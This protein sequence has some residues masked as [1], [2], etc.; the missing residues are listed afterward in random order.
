MMPKSSYLFFKVL[1]LGAV[2]SEIFI[3]V[4]RVFRTKMENETQGN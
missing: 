2:V 3:S 4:N 1:N